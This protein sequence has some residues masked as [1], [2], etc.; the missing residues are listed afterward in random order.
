VKSGSAKP[1]SQLCDHLAAAIALG[2][3]CRYRGALVRK[4]LIVAMLA[5]PALAFA[6][7]SD[8]IDPSRISDSIRILASDDFA[9]RAPDSEGG[10]KAVD[11]I[12]DTF[13]SAGL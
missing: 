5:W 6:V 8:T 11:Y 10:R 7:S 9:G 13:Q 1:K 2:F 3:R 12:V 4:V